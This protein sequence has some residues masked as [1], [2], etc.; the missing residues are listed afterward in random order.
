M[1]TNRINLW[2]VALAKIK[3]GALAKRS[4]RDDHS[5]RQAEAR[6]EFKREAEA[7]KV[8]DEREAEAKK[9]VNDFRKE[10]EARD[11]E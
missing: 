4:A 11:A 7:K 6:A 1:S 8:V 5:R 3:A 10:R 2:K 9:V